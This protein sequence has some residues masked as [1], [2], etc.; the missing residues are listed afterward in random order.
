MA[1]DGDTDLLAA[2]LLNAFGGNQAAADLV[3]Q[4]YVAGK[5]SQ[6]DTDTLPER[7][8]GEIEKEE[9]ARTEQIEDIDV[10]QWLRE[11]SVGPIPKTPSEAAEWKRENRSDPNVKN[12]AGGQGSLYDEDTGFLIFKSPN[13]PPNHV[14]PRP[15]GDRANVKA[16]FG[17]KTTQNWDLLYGK[18]HNADGTPKTEE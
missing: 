14:E 6:I 9:E 5:L 13:L 3:T 11:G 10:E 8:I 16:G 12:V 1:K 2:E 17:S 7:A 15:G 18:T 4:N